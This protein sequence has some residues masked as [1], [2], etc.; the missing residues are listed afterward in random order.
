M[1]RTVSAVRHPVFARL[2]PRLARAMDE[3]GL[4]EHR[5]QLL[6]GLSGEVVEIGAGHGANF[7]HYL[8][9]V[10]RVRAVEPEP[11]LRGIARTAAADAPVPVEVSEGLADELPL[12]DRS[13]DAAVFCLVLCSVPDP[14]SALQE[15]RRVLRPGGQLRVLEHVRADS[16]VM[17]RVQRLMDAT[18]WPALAG[19]CHTSRD[20]AAEIERAGFTIDRLDRFLFPEARTPF[21]FHVLAAAHVG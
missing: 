2:Y 12:A 21:A 19:G 7:A 20:T 14:L 6:A 4:V 13:M 9:A 11:R 1:V 5:Q 15:A 10:T 8:P 3:G 18:F 17:A 16:P